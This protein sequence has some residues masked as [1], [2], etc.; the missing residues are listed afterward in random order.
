MGCGGSDENPGEMNTKSGYPTE[1]NNFIVKC[2]KTG[3]QDEFTKLGV[4]EQEVDHNPSSS[5]E[6]KFTFKD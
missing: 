2:S 3:E 4:F 1:F 5:K 6:E